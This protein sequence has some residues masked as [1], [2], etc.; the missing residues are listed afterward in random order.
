MKFLSYGEI[1]RPS[2]VQIFLLAPLEQFFIQQQKQ[3]SKDKKISAT[4][5]FTA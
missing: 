1:H 3:L 5:F 4:Y 2:S